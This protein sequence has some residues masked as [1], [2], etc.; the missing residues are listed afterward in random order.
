MNYTKLALAVAAG[1][2]LAAAVIG[3]VL[4]LSQPTPELMP[5]EDGRETEQKAAT[6][7][8]ERNI[9]RIRDPQ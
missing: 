2:L 4:W 6:E 5:T 1:V 7:R 3:A 8:I 9:T